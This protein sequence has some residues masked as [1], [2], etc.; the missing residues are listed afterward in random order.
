[1]AGCDEK[2]AK[3]GFIDLHRDFLSNFDGYM[4]TFETLIDSLGAGPRKIVWLTGAGIS[5]ESGIPTFRGDEGYWRV[6][7][8]N[9]HPTELATR[10]AFEQMPDEI[11]AWYLYRRSVCLL[12]EPNAAHRA[13]AKLEGEFEDSFRLITQNVDGLHLRAGNSRKRTY[14]IHGEIDRMRCA[15][16]CNSEL[17]SIPREIETSWSKGRKLSQ[18]ERA[19]LRCPDC[20]ARSRPHVLWFDE[21]YDEL[22]FRFD[23]SLRAAQNAELLVIVG[24]SGSTNLPNQVAR[25]AAAAGAAII[26][27]NPEAT[28]F[29]AM[30]EELERGIVLSGKAGQWVPQ[31]CERL[32]RKCS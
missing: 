19:L 4:T 21:C 15:E 5:A 18:S 9:Y 17:F 12:A 13:L 11:W 7:S 29:S 23:S 25:L 14:Q 20:G 32:A 1:M 16:S 3:P 10:V 26:V 24:T 2:N 28:I 31:L 30:A 6:G 22:F 27:A 8:K